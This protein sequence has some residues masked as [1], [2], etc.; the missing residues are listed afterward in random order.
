MIASIHLQSS[1]IDVIFHANRPFNQLC[2]S[3]MLISKVI[4]MLLKLIA[5]ISQPLFIAIMEKSRNYCRFWWKEFRK[6]EPS[7][8][9]FFQM[10]FT[11]ISE[12]FNKQL[13]SRL[14]ASLILTDAGAAGSGH[15][16]RNRK[17]RVH[18]GH[19]TSSGDGSGYTRGP[20]PPHDPAAGCSSWDH[21]CKNVVRYL[22]T[23]SI[24]GSG[25]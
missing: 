7:D 2:S 11:L 10:I 13:T 5:H 14:T 15:G 3:L 17:A 24:T 4:R 8:W 23:S 12:S 21:G 20:T 18:V 16:D 9:L 22:L 6:F 25:P 19:G 1:V